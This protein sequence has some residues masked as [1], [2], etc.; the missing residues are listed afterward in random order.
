MSAR[1]KQQERRVS[2]FFGVERTPLSGG[3]SRHT[4]SDTLHPDLYIEIKSASKAESSNG[5]F[6]RWLKRHDW[7][8]GVLCYHRRGIYFYLMHSR[9]LEPEATF[10]IRALRDMPA[11]CMRLWK[12]TQELAAQE[13]KTP[14]VAFC[15]K[16]KRGFWVFGEVE[17]VVAAEKARKETVEHGE[18]MDRD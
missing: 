17:D 6:W 3:A 12:Q 5:Y 8:Q 9:C 14:L 15:C 16:G 1:S 13:K 18:N 11:G 2:R 10:R 7:P 4:R